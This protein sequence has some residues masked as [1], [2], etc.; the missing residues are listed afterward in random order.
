[1]K[2][3][4]KELKYVLIYSRYIVNFLSQLQNKIQSMVLSECSKTIYCICKFLYK[5]IKKDVEEYIPNF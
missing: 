2:A 5:Y 3:E 4:F 1:M